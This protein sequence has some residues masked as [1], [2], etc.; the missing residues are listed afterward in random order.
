MYRLRSGLFLILLLAAGCSA[1]RGG[2]FASDLV[3]K[4]APD[5]DLRDVQGKTVRLSELRGKPVILAFFAYG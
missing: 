4:P 2:R 5:F 3:R 1:A